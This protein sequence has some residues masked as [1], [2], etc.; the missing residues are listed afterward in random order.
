M[1]KLLK[2]LYPICRSITGKGFLKSLKIIKKKSPEIMIKS[3]NSGK[4]VFDWK[5]PNEWNVKNANV[6]NEKGEI[7]IDF[8][9]HNLHLVS[10]SIAVKNKKI[11][12][13]DLLS[14]V[15]TLPKQPNVI[16]YVTSYYKK[17]WGFCLEHNNLKKFFKNK[18][19]IFTVNIDTSLKSNGKMYYGECFIRGKSKKEVLIST[20]LCHPS[21][22]NNELSGPIVLESLIRYFKKKNNNYSLR[23]LILPE[24]IGSIA[25]I[26]NNYDYLKKN[27]IGGF[28]L[29]CLGDKGKF[30]YL[31]S[32]E[33]DSISNSIVKEYF[34]KKGISY[35]EYSYLDRGSDE[36]QYNSVGINL[37]IGSLMRSKYGTFQE[38]HTS[39]DNLKFVTPKQ[40]KK[41]FKVVKGIIDEFMSVK[42]PIT[43][44]YC[45]PHLTKYGLYRTLSTKDLDL[46]S[47][48]ILN[49][50][51]YCDGKKDLVIISKKI[52]L[53]LNQVYKIFKTLKQKKIIK[54][55]S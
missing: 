23:F 19:E 50:L 46:N 10:Y 35:K 37:Q 11:S 20:Y 15:H 9:K 26:Y 53:N 4:K 40:L 48:N 39:A 49:F 32:K 36:R 21:M 28:V 5:I 34:I 38:Y 54:E 8:K 41:S 51:S 27:V 1:K 6:K 2:E 22:A 31:K 17:Y 29:T 52:N 33:D 24:T 14:R 7:I 42:I 3:L 43:K 13:N 12:T 30:S 47:R 45:E 18:K 25:Y 16:P 55:I 44:I